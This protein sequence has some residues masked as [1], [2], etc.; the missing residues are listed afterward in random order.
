MGQTLSEPIVEKHTS[1][2]EDEEFAFG[3]SEMQGWRL[4]MEDAHAAVLDLNHAPPNSS[5]TTPASTEP[6]KER[7]RFFAV[8]DGH[9]GSTVAK[10][11]GDTV[12]F[13]LRSTA[14]Y[15]SGDYEAALKRA[16][17]ATD[18]DLRANPDFVNDPSGCTAVAAL[19]TPDGKIMVANAGDSRSV[20]SVNGLA[21]PMSHDHKPVNRG[22]NN[23]IVAAGGFVEFGRVNGN[24]ALSR[25]IGDFE[26]KQ[27]KELSPEA[28]VVTANP[29]ILT[30]QITA[31]DEFLILACDGIWD[32]YS[33]QQVVDRVRRLLGERKTLEQVAEQMID[34]CLAPDCEWGGVGCDNM[35]FMI[36]AILGG[37]TKAEW[38]DMIRTRLERGEGHQTP[39]SFPQPYARGPRGEILAN[40]MKVVMGNGSGEDHPPPSPPPGY[41]NSQDDPDHE[42]QTSSS[43]PTSAGSL[44]SLA[45]VSIIEAL[46]RVS[47]YDPTASLSDP[48]TT[49]PV[50]SDP[51]SDAHPPHS[52]ETEPS[53]TTGP[54]DSSSSQPPPSSSNTNTNAID[55]STTTTTSN[56]S[57]STAATDDHASTLSQSV[58]NS[59]LASSDV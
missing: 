47:N 15:Q 9:G 24:L 16:F 26:F 6:T 55:S 33:N 12:H 56:T 51:S 37:K 58:D 57:S 50:S 38:Y 53:T 13:R 29:D 28:Q 36:V 17:L 5:S 18:E 39:S 23:R 49:G 43:N 45:P 8:Y 14:E 10:F 31:E 42:Q 11:S 41:Q 46:S 35:T 34:Y 2:G 52:S 48:P 4:T 7:T 54:A 19:I 20:L 25:A 1:A 59:K 21:E 40:S 27:N 22:E 3:V 32:V 30:H 44:F